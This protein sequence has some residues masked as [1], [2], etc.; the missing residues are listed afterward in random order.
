MLLRKARIVAGCL[1]A[2]LVLILYVR[3]LSPDFLARVQIFVSIPEVTLGETKG[4][5]SGLFKDRER[6]DLILTQRALVASYPVYNT[7]KEKLTQKKQEIK[8][9]STGM[10]MALQDIVKYII[11]GKQHEISANLYDWG[12]FD[13][14]DRISFST[15]IQGATSRLASKVQIP[16]KH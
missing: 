5:F 15:D 4:M 3:S 11:L 10:E 8:P 1:L 9:V 6:T 14:L 12:Y 13:F 16:S 7:V 2:Y